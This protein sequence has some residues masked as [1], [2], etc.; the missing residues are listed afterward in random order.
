MVVEPSVSLFEDIG[1]E[2]NQ[3]YIIII[4]YSKGRASAYS[5]AE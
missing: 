4:T 1:V 5:E 2:N 3:V